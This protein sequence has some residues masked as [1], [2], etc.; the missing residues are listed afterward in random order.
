MGFWGRLWMGN[1]FLR[2]PMVFF[3]LYYY[4]KGLEMYKTKSPVAFRKPSSFPEALQ[5]L[6]SLLA[7]QKARRFPKAPSLRRCSAAAL[8]RLTAAPEK[9]RWLSQETKGELKGNNGLPKGSEAAQ[10]FSKAAQL[11]G[12]S[13]GYKKS[14]FLPV[15][16]NIFWLSWAS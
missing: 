3:M 14:G 1:C 16:H 6:K 13:K 7:L 11:L 10:L 12:P 4:L 8:L 2:M 15:T 9:P 5:L